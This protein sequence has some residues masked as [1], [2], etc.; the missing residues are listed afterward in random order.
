MDGGGRTTSGAKVEGEGQGAMGWLDVVGGVP[1]PVF[2][3]DS[4]A[5]PYA[6]YYSLGGTPQQRPLIPLVW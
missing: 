4:S 5:G 1:A 6:E 3:A 2:P